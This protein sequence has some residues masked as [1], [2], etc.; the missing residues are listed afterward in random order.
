MVK[1]EFLIKI[2]SFLTFTFLFLC[3]ACVTF[4]REL[5]DELEGLNEDLSDGFTFLDFCLT[6]SS[7][8]KQVIFSPNTQAMYFGEDEDWSNKDSIRLFMKSWGKNLRKKIE[9]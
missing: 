1:T 3:A 2:I 7:Q 9:G 4:T 5:F 8:N 6:A